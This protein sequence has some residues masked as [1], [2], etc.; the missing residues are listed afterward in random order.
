MKM[1]REFLIYA[2]TIAEWTRCSSNISASTYKALETGKAQ[3]IF[4]TFSATFPE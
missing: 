2:K 1:Y 4:D 3:R